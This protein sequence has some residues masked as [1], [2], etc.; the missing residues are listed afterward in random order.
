MIGK[1]DGAGYVVIWEFHVRPRMSRRFEAAY[2]PKGDWARLFGRDRHYR[3]TLL[4]SSLRDRRTY[5]TL[6]FWSSKHA[7]ESFRKRYAKEYKAIDAKCERLT[8]SERE[9]GR[10]ISA[11]GPGSL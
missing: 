10:Y 7:Y 11:T 4:T 6:D 2:G 5:L 8:E 3:G 9:I 1:L